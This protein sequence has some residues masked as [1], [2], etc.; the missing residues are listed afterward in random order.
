MVRV[1]ASVD[2]FLLRRWALHAH[3]MISNS[4][5]GEI[6]SYYIGSARER[7]GDD[8]IGGLFRPT[9]ARGLQ[10]VA[11]KFERFGNNSVVVVY[12]LTRK[13]TAHHRL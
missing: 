6:K 3:K 7:Y 9:P 12:D 2:E 4:S 8:F 5:T 1:R 11:L 10:F 13:L